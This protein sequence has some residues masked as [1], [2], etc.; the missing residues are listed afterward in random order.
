MSAQSQKAIGEKRTA[1]VVKALGKR[2]RDI[3]TI[4][5]KA[6]LER[7][8]ARRALKRAE[9]AGKVRVEKKGTANLYALK[10]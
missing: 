8:L 5:S 7:T 2:P 3:D 10:N 4:A 1:A 9:D 6:K